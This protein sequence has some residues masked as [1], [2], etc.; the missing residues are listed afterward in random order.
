MEERKSHKPTSTT[1]TTPANAAKAVQL[2]TDKTLNFTKEHA[3][4]YDY[5]FC[6]NREKWKSSCKRKIGVESLSSHKH[7]HLS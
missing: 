4:K 5:Y 7:T 1:T 6:Q 2:Q 3:K